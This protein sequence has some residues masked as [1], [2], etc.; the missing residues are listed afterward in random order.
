LGLEL[1]HEI[2]GGLDEVARVYRLEVFLGEPISFVLLMVN[3]LGQ[4]LLHR[5]EL[6]HELGESSEFNLI[7]RKGLG[8]IVEHSVDFQVVVGARIILLCFLHECC[9]HSLQTCCSGEI[10]VGD[11]SMGVVL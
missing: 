4:L 6:E 9:K 11:R 8:H 1:P 3:A 2:G 5:G 10:L 7:F